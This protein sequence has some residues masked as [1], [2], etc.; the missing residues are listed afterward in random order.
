MK[1]NHLFAWTLGMTIL[2]PVLVACGGAPPA[3]SS[4]TTAPA[5]AATTAPAPA[6]TTAP[7]PAAGATIGDMPQNLRTDLKGQTIKF[8][9]HAAGP[10]S[11]FEKKYAAAFEQMTGIK[12]EVLQGPQSA[13]ERIAQYLQ[14]LGA[15][16]SD[17]DVYMIDVIWPGILADHAVDLTNA[18][19]SQNTDYFERIVKNNTVNGKLVGIPM[20][21][22]AGLLFYRT[23]LLKK[24]G[25]DKPPATWAELEQMAQKI[26]D[27]ERAAGK[28]D[29][30][31]YVWQGAAYEG[32]TCDALEWQFSQ[33]GGTIIEPDGTISINNANA[34]KAFERAKGWI[35]MIS[36]PGVTTYK[37][38]EARGV[39]QAGNA[40]FM[41]NWGYAY[42][43]GQ[44]ADSPIKDKFDVTILP[45]GDGANGQ[46]AATL[47]GWQIMVSK[48]SKNQEA[49]IEWAK[50]LTSR[51][52]QKKRVLEN[53][54]EPT[55]A[56]LYQDPD[57]L[58]ALPYYARYLS[59]FRDG[60]VARPSTVSADLYNDVSAAYFTAVNQVLTGNTDAKTAVAD[61]ETKLK[62]IL[63]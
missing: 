46:P 25:F 1:R 57:I 54:L 21:V 18:L 62:G 3:T 50:F 37:E 52:I 41:R 34:I 35:G 10:S 27:G 56:S 4:A 15:Q 53:S 14:Q 59:V 7:A 39:W 9:G 42:A 17:V 28:P 48:Y 32:L 31:G 2:L 16:S 12:V 40:A 13:T 5:P 44:A 61:L 6:V 60:A 63:K 23:D 47:G 30:W 58:K 55:I 20:Y 19:K 29:F 43:L 11:D 8:I 38:E 36:P 51:E 24:Y 22:G 33:G 26:Q 45:K 49:A